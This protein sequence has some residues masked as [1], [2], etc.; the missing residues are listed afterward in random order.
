MTPEPWTGTGRA[1]PG[2]PRVQGDVVRTLLRRRRAL[3]HLPRVSRG[4]LS[5]DLEGGS[6]PRG[7]DPQHDAVEADPR[8]AAGLPRH[9]ARPAGPDLPRRALR[10]VQGDS[11]GDAGRP[12]APA[13]VRA[14]ALRGLAHARG[15]SVRL[16]SRRRPRH[17]RRPRAE[18]P[19]PRD[20]HR[21]RRQGPPA[22]RR[23]A[24]A[25]AVGARPHRREA[26]VRRGQ[27]ARALGRGAGADRRRARA[28][29]RQH[30]QHPRGEGRR[31]EDG[32]EAHRPVRRRRRDLR[33]PH[34]GG[35]QAA[36][37]PGRQ[38][39]AGAPLARAGHRESSR[40]L[41]L[42]PG[43]VPARGAGLAQAPQPLDGDG[44]RAAHQG[45]AGGDGGGERHAGPPPGDRGRRARLAGEDSRGPS[46]R[47]RLGRRVS[48]ARRHLPWGGGVPS[49]AGLRLPRRRR[50]A[51]VPRAPARGPRRETD[52][53]MGARPGPPGAARGRQRARRLSP[54]RRA[55]HLQARRDL[56]RG[57]RGVPADA[58][59]ADGGA[60]RP[61]RAR[62]RRASQVGRAVLGARRGGSDGAR[63][64]GD[65]RRRG[66]S[67]RRGAGDDGAPRHPCRS[68]AARG[69]RQG[70]RSQPRQPHA[71]DLPPRGRGVHDR[72]P[73]AARAHPL[74]EAEAA[75]DPPHE[76]RL[77]DGRRRPHGARPP[78]RAAR[79][80]PR[81]PEPRQAEGHVRRH[82]ARGS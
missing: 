27:G 36:R 62:A 44:V 19:G 76:D 59:A 21:H 7:A 58:A 39:E 30:R 45:A 51:R 35:R 46:R 52:R 9:R 25:R 3:A 17:A 75:G 4:R 66:A 68:R 31:R 11:H 50:A 48:P 49:G 24:R 78:P 38:Q 29:G 12:R 18:D 64:A 8:G 33:E 82:A 14:A 57:V 41:S 55:R 72:V 80:D 10:R 37:D 70:A 79:E 73:E 56:R 53:R 81:A 67:A 16:R 22:A 42:R 40:R 32:R 34:A 61:P 43:D 20:R 6:E 69:V 28:H 77:L 2:S 54:Q 71:R 65:L 23:P 1:K 74:R 60:R 15:G 5:L 13:A 47:A 63:A 26:R